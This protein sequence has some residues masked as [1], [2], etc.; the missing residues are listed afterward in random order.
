MA[1]FEVGFILN[2]MIVT[3]F[4]FRQLTNPICKQN[5]SWDHQR[6]N[7][8]YFWLL[9]ALETAER[10]NTNN[11]YDQFQSIRISIRDNIS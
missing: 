5:V 6:G 1:K 2:S 10:K 7:I 3:V 9:S 4:G 11:K 8:W